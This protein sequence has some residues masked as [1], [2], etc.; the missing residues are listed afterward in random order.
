MSKKR[1]S[2]QKVSRKS[3][4]TRSTR[5]RSRSR[6]SGKYRAS[7]DDVLTPFYRY[8]IT[9]NEHPPQMFYGTH[10]KY[11]ESTKRLTYF[12]WRPNWDQKRKAEGYDPSM[13]HEKYVTPLHHVFL[14]EHETLTMTQLRHSETLT[15]I[16]GFWITHD[17]PDFSE[18]G[19]PPVSRHD[20]GGQDSANHTFMQQ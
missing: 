1:R 14:A 3:S 9:S 17:A 16:S 12:P 8:E 6:R 4:K 20:R 18:G 11:Y 10:V 7:S 5:R 2:K 15:L 19:P 13:H